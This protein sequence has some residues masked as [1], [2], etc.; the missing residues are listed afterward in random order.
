[1]RGILFSCLA[2]SFLFVAGCQ[3]W[4]FSAQRTQNLQ[5]AGT[6]GLMKIE[7]SNGSV[8]VIGSDAELID[9]QAKVTAN[10]PTQEDAD[11]ML[12]E[13]E[14]HLDEVDGGFRLYST[15]PK[16]FRGGVSYEVTL[17]RGMSVD[18]N[19][20]NGAIEV[21]G[22]D[23]QSTLESSNGAIKVVG[24]RSTV[25]AKTSN[26]AV[27]VDAVEPVNVN[28][29]S[30]NGRITFK[31]GLV[32]DDN[33]VRTSNGA[34]EVNLEGAAVDVNASTSNGRITV[35]EAGEPSSTSTKKTKLS[36]V[37]GTGESEGRKLQL[38]TSNGSITI[39]HTAGSSEATPA[40]AE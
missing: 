40:A 9:V 35:E 26:G 4:K 5:V 8:K 17:P 1:M 13:V 29:R 22:I 21:A 16:L 3:N 39:R 23:G 30:S 19:S 37:V 15:Q 25:K 27:S 2:C 14:I 11:A 10:G 38:E 36:Q 18:A 28:L 20:S 12:S 24:A 33:I 6:S 32:G 31:G 7:T 34:I